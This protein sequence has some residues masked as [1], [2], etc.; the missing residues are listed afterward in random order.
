[1]AKKVKC[2]KNS[3]TEVS[4]LVRGKI[5]DRTQQVL[6]SIRSLFPSSPII[7]STWKNSVTTGLDFDILVE[8]D[9][10][11]ALIFNAPKDARNDG[12]GNVIFELNGKSYKHKSKANNVNRIIKTIQGGLEK[13]NTKYV[14]SIRTDIILKNR[15]FLEYW[16]MFPKYN[17][18]YKIF[19]HR[20][21]N[22]SS[23]AQF[24]H[25]MKNGIQL[26]PFHMSDWIHFGLVEDVKLLY[27]CPLQDLEN[28]AQYWYTHTRKQYDPFI[29]AGWQY[30]PETYVLYSLVKQKFPNVDFKDS[31]D[32]NSKN[33]AVS[34]M[35]MAD[36]FIFID[37]ND[38]I[39]DIDKY[40]K[41][42]E[43]TSE[44]Y[45]G[46]ITYREFQNLYKIYCDKFYKFCDIDYERLRYYINFFNP[47]YLIKYP[48]KYIR[49]FNDIKYVFNKKS[50][51]E[52]FYIGAIDED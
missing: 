38:F 4:I 26:L 52:K 44:I 13:V 40:P 12:E 41:L 17:G 1:M 22:S 19:E 46:F 45:N 30:P 10:P 6:C 20:I 32:F 48:G 7:L 5:E 24:A 21:I 23:F 39:F 9:D 29:E 49:L 37:Q 51:R 50:L 33:M 31:D 14:L 35:I 3:N 15:K 18:K 28:S 16:D 47:L 11:G 8:N 27:S 36:N 34:N 25:V 2:M 42:K 43:W